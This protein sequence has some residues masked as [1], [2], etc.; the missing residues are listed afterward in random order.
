MKILEKDGGNMLTQSQKWA[1]K[2]NWTKF[3]LEGLIGVLNAFK[4]DP[5]LLNSEAHLAD[6]AL[7]NLEIIKEN[8]KEDNEL[9]KKEY[10]KEK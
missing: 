9:S 8:W 2:R 10:L 3:K 1:Q 5:I 7:T 4:R 6:R